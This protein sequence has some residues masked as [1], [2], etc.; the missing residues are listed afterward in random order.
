MCGSPLAA[1][2][3]ERTPQGPLREAELSADLLTS[4]V[5]DSLLERK[6]TLGSSHCFSGRP[7]PSSLVE[8]LSY[9][10]LLGTECTHQPVPLEGRTEV[11]DLDERCCPRQSQQP[12]LL[13]VL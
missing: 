11:Q 13:L 9:P 1:S 5:C 2:W 10:E 7:S 4:Y 6:D 8:G 12:G 3:T